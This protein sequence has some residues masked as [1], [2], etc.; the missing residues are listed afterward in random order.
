MEFI[1]GVIKKKACKV[2]KVHQH[3]VHIFR[4]RPLQEISGSLGDLGTLLPIIIALSDSND[5]DGN[6][7]GHGISLPSTLVFSGLAN[8]F[9]GVFF[10]IPLPV[11]P[12]KAIAAVAIARN[13]TQGE[14]ASA[15]LFVAGIIGVLSITGLLNWFARVIPIPVVKGIQ[16]G[17]G[18]S[19]MTSAGALAIIR[20][21]CDFEHQGFCDMLPFIN[22]FFALSAIGLLLYSQVHSRMPY[23]LIILICCVFIVLPD[24]LL[25]SANREFSFWSPKPFVP[26]LH[27]FRIG[28]LDAAIGQIP[29]TTLNS[30]IAV[31]HLAG[32]LLPEVETPSAT[33]IGISVTTMNLVGCWFGAMPVCHGSGGLA[34]QYR[35]GA[36]SGASI[37]FLGSIKLFLGL[38]VGRQTLA[39][40]N[41]FP[42]VQLGIM[43]F[44][45][46]LELAKVGESLNN[47]GARDLWEADES[48]IDGMDCKRMKVLTQE[49]RKKRWAVMLVTIGGILSFRNDGVGFLAGMMLH[50]TYVWHDRQEARSL[51]SGG[52]IRLESG[53][54]V[55]DI[56]VQPSRIS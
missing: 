23:A 32:D 51:G 42:K 34:A 10:G 56:D 43:I 38:F 28:I 1:H 49:E 55:A 6:R 7:Y 41:Q 44:V 11:Q 47:E 50:W 24:A 17:T 25:Y 21:S 9:T 8:I 53:R 16:V 54:P 48:D 45:A 3:N 46:G 15:G 27:D 5:L 29:L 14:L 37:I 4:Q 31:T 30:I 18:L 40:F 39:F 19:L 2:R 33:S 35:F 22:L 26:S 13:F 12:M 20:G 36:R 52:Q